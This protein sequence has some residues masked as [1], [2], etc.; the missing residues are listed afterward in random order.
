MNPSN[1]PRAS[2]ANAPNIAAR[3]K[4]MHLALDMFQR[5]PSTALGVGLR[6]RIRRHQHRL[7]HLAETGVIRLGRV[8]L[9]SRRLCRHNVP[10]ASQLTRATPSIP[11]PLSAQACSSASSA[12]WSTT[13]GRGAFHRSPGRRRNGPQHYWYVRRRNQLLAKMEATTMRKMRPLFPAVTPAAASSASSR[14]ARLS[15]LPWPRRSRLR[16]RMGPRSH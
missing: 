15:R 6:K 8:P 5:A 13:I 3:Y 2:I 4:S 11:S 14:P 1:M 7:R 16:Q 9:H 10:P 12:E